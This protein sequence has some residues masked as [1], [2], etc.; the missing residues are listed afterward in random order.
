MARK[1]S[2]K[3]SPYERLK[4]LSERLVTARL[5]ADANKTPKVLFKYYSAKRATEVLEHQRVYFSHPDLFNDP[6][7]LN[8]HILDIDVSEQE[9]A[10]FASE[11][12]LE[13]ITEDRLRESINTRSSRALAIAEWKRNRLVFSMSETCNDLLM[14]AHYGQKHTGVVIGFNVNMRSFALRQDGRPR[15]LSKVRYSTHRPSA[16]TLADLRENE[17]LLTKSLE[18]AHEREWRLFE[19]P[20][21][22][23]GESKSTAHSWPF[24]IK[25]NVIAQVV[26]G[27]RAETSVELKVAGLLAEDRYKHV[28]FRQGVV[29]EREFKIHVG[30][31]L[32]PIKT[33]RTR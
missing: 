23:D 24:D 19:N 20:F 13:G 6:F 27:A 18:W 1:K 7:E 14:W 33:K 11:L 22:A 3:Q 26:L 31:P 4:R 10:D 17:I 8:P 30:I 32:M 5:A 21:N 15:S 29:D 12:G 2:P 25:A 28:K 9:L 16:K